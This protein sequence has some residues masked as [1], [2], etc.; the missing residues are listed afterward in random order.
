MSDF[1]KNTDNQL[2]DKL[3]QHEFEQM[4]A[5]WSQMEQMLQ[6]NP[7][8]ATKVGGGVLWWA[9]PTA[10]AAAVLAGII[11][12]G[13][14]LNPTTTNTAEGT[15]ILANQERVEQKKTL[16]SQII[17]QKNQRTA[18]PVIKNTI[19]VPPIKNT[20]QETAAAS[21]TPNHT[22]MVGVKSNQT[23]TKNTEEKASSLT[24]N[25][26]AVAKEENST[27][28]NSTAP[29]LSQP[30]GV[31]LTDMEIKRPIKKTRTIV[32]YQ[33]SMTPFKALS[34]KKRSIKN[35]L[36]Q[37]SLNAFGITEEPYSK[38]KALKIGAFAGVSTKVIGSTQK[39][40]VMPTAGMT[41]N[42]RMSGKS[43]L[44]TGLQYKT[45]DLKGINSNSKKEEQ[46]FRSYSTSAKAYSLDRVD[47]LEI[48]LVY[49]YYPNPKFN[50]HAGVKGAW[51]FNKDFSDPSLKGTTN[52]AIGLATFDLGALL[53]IEVLVNKHVSVGL[54]YSVGVLNLTN[55]AKM[56]HE[57]A[58]EEQGDYG[59]KAA[60]VLDAG[61][62][63]IPVN[64][65]QDKMVRLPGNMRNSDIQ[66]LVKYTF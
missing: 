43:A 64:P 18:N 34:E 45:I 48:P 66:L 7:A 32:R 33:Y 51:L 52:N 26:V 23:T 54:Q 1:Y 15:T 49:Q 44:Q 5:A 29:A 65:S 62:V 25:M 19:A 2:R 41:L 14:Y 46:G 31:D 17:A 57:I 3:A 40:S 37:G 27:H 60:T 11:T 47:M 4:P 16:S 35:T 50:I 55:E 6:A 63:L 53:G 42:Y 58:K 22:M 13:V 21:A 24:T 8:T 20:G 9:L 61:E 12:V 28:L 59:T 38:S 36:P 30:K 10:A 39:V 56:T